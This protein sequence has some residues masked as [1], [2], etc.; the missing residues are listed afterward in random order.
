M[1]I[2]LNERQVTGES[3]IENASTENADAT[4]GTTAG[5]EAEGVSMAASTAASSAETT[6]ASM[7]QLKWSGQRRVKF[8]ITG[9]AGPI[10]CLTMAWFGFK[11]H[12][13]DLWQSGRLDVYAGLMLEWPSLVPFLPLLVL[14]MVALGAICWD[15]CYVRLSWV[16]LGLYGGALLSIQYLIAVIASTS[17]MSVIVAAMWGPAL[18]WWCMSEPS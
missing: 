4:S 15:P 12:A 6:T 14:S 1:D 11:S 10:A 16:R 5:E 9:V 13:N 3:N 17:L 2:P 8:F 18:A 7:G